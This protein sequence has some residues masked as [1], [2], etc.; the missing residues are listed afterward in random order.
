LPLH[1]IITEAGPCNIPDPCEPG[2]PTVNVPTGSRIAAYLLMRNHE[3]VVALQTAFDWGDWVFIY[4]AWDCQV[5]QI[6]GT[7]P[8]P[9]GGP[10]AGTIATAFN[11]VTGGS[12]EVIGRMHFLV[13]TTDGA[14]STQGCL[15]QVE[16]AYPFGTHVVATSFD[17]AP[18]LPEHRGSI[19]V[20]SGGFDACGPSATAVDATTWGAIKASYR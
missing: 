1:A 11:S 13:S 4:G 3:Q 15:T 16:S 8:A 9:P 2:P 12:T 5:G 20:G 7:A 18:V 14:R 19:C 6:Y 17:T 10:G